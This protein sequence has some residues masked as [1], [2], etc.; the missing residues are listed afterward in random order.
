MEK[1]RDVIDYEG[2]YEV[3]N[4]GRVR[5]VDRMVKHKT[6]S[7]RKWKGKILAQPPVSQKGYPGLKLSKEGVKRTRYVHHLVAEAWLGPCPKGQQVRHGPNGLDNSIENLSY[8][9]KSEDGFDKR[10]DGTHGGRPVRRSDG[11]VF[12]NMSVAVEETGC[13]HSNIWKVCNG[14]RKRTGGYGW[15]YI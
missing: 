2:F 6:G 5:S 14:R 4:L 15:E 13:P 11:V 7:M 10:R 12:L 8:G 1:W 3:S 9:T